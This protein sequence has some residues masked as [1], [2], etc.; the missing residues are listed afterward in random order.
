M[1]EIFSYYRWVAGLRER[2]LNLQL[3][4]TT[5]VFAPEMDG[6][7]YIQITRFTLPLGWLVQPSPTQ[8]P[9]FSLGYA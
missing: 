9:K 5:R 2:G 3:L 6:V 7:Y 4:L 1:V 8:G